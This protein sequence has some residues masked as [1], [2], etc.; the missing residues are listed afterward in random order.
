M[1]TRSVSLVT[2][3]LFGVAVA[4]GSRTSLESRAAVAQPNP[5]GDGVIDPG[6]N[7]D[8]GNLESSDSCIATCEKARCGDG[9]VHVGVELCD[10]GLSADGGSSG[11]A[12]GGNDGSL[13]GGHCTAHCGPFTC[14]DGVVQ[15]PEVC[16]DA[17]VDNTDAC[18]AS[19]LV[20]R[21]GDGFV[22]AGVEACDDGDALDTNDCTTS[23][24][25]ARCGDGITWKGHEECDDGNV[26][27]VD[28][29][30]N[31]CKLPVCGDGKVAGSEAC[32]LGTGNGNQPAFLISQ[33]SGTR[34]GTNPLFRK[35]TSTLFY[36]YSSASSHTGLEQVGESR[37]YL[38]VDAGTGRLSLVLTHGIDQDSTGQ[39]QPVSDVN[40][41]ITGL[42]SGFQID[43]AD[44]T[45]DE[46]FPTSSTTASGRWHFNGNSDGGVLGNL[47]FPG[48]WKIVVTPTFTQ[49]I[50]TW[51]WVND[52]LQR[53]PLVMTEAIT[54]QAF[55]AKAR[56]RTSCT[57]PRCGD[58][59]L[60][61]GEV[62]DD[63]NTV[64]GDGCSATCTALK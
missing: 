15:A 30:D 4:C 60:D 49:G 1:R 42:P 47:A 7:C 56:C 25:L 11:D 52:T 8:D 32:D 12:T 22:R 9:I 40:M 34:I 13:D 55:D 54:I 51:G 3:A 26:N 18:L 44:D 37:I 64:G 27:D 21:C 61:G 39:T 41:D 10:E 59:V 19:C 6:E 5:C 33:P 48:T 46:F 17:N 57:V 31:H 2:F 20:A 63:G 43:L 28:G 23:C 58:G 62:C 16:D 45:S 24:A 29:C 14:G 38:Y 36:D 53:I 50:T 35:K